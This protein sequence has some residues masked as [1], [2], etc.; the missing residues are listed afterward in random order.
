VTPEGI[1]QAGWFDRWQPEPGRLSLVL[2]TARHKLV[3][4]GTSVSQEH[5]ATPTPLVALDVGLGLVSFVSA[6][7]S[8]PVVAAAMPLFQLLLIDAATAD[9]SL[10]FLFHDGCQ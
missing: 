8:D 2:Q 6:V 7:R 9:A 4:F 1:N 3:S 10:L 5:C